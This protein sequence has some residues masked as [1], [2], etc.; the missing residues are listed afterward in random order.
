MRDKNELLTCFKNAKDSSKVNIEKY[1]TDPLIIDW[2]DLNFSYEKFKQ[3]YPN[4]K[5]EELLKNGSN[6]MLGKTCIYLKPHQLYTVLQT[7]K[8]INNHDS[9]DISILWGHV[10][11]SGKTYI[12]AGLIIEMSKH[13]NT[14]DKNYLIVTT[15]PN[16][17]ISQ[18]INVLNCMELCNFNIINYSKNKK[19][20]GNNNIIICSKQLLTYKSNQDMKFKNV[21]CVFFDEAHYGG[22]TRLSKELL[23]KYKNSIKIFIF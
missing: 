23:L 15:F 5:I 22:A 18:Y 2:K 12:L 20:I 16:E 14:S 19:I 6:D 17:T 3:I 4:I 10:P 21:F 9:Y 11:R 7:I 1:I 13:E 8:L